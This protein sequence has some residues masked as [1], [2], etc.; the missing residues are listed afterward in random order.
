MLGRISSRVNTEWP[1]LLGEWYHL[2]R[3]EG[4]VQVE[5]SSQQRYYRVSGSILVLVG[6]IPDPEK[7]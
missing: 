5:H 2:N 4:C 6:G 3:G 1:K 7:N